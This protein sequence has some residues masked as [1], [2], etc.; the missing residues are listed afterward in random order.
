MKPSAAGSNNKKNSSVVKMSFY[1]LSG[2]VIH[3]VHCV[4]VNLIRPEVM[5]M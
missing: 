1:C 4:P 5:L 2:T 3:Y